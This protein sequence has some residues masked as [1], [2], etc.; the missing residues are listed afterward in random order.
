MLTFVTRL[1]VGMM[2]QPPS[3]INRWANPCWPNCRLSHMAKVSTLRKLELHVSDC[4]LSI[5]IE[6][7]LD[8]GPSRA[9]NL[10]LIHPS[11]NGIWRTLV[12]SPY[13]ILAGVVYKTNARLWLES[14]VWPGF[15]LKVTRSSRAASTTLH[16]QERRGAWIGL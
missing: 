13:Q 10:C 12:P 2:S 16:V 4:V 1:L 15:R 5:L 8:R 6:P 11:S 14:F 9:L 7:T 3:L